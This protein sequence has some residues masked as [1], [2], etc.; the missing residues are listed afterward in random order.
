MKHEEGMPV[1]EAAV[2][3]AR[4]R[5]RP[6]LMT[7]LAF[8]LGAIPLVIA[9]GAGAN[10]RHSIGTG[11]V[12]GMTAA[13]VLAIFFV[14][15]FFRLFEGLSERGGKKTLHPNPPPQGGRESLALE[16]APSLPSPSR[17]GVGGE[18]SSEDRHDA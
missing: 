5:F 14:P 9:T 18:G 7:S 11:I 12:G 16:T 2:E 13:T 17:R 15:M 8:I 4:L 6:I 3:A 1:L 10:S